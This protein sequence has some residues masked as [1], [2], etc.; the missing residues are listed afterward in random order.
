MRFAD[1]LLTI[2]ATATLTSAA[3][4]VVGTIYLGNSNI[5]PAAPQAA[6]TDVSAGARPPSAALAQ[7]GRREQISAPAVGEF[8]QLVMPV[9]SVRRDQLVDTFDDPRSGGERLHQA[10]DIMAPRGAPVVAA[11]P[12][13]I[14]R[15]FQ[16]EAGGNTVYVR[17][18]DRRTIYYYAHLD[19]YAAG[20]A[21]G[22]RVASG[23]PL[24][25]VGSTGNASPDA[26][27]LHFA[28]LRTTPDAGWSDPATA[29]DPFPL[30]RR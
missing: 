18:G 17:S 11:A 15:L 8:A 1:R 24:G 4:I 2:V 3:W 22:A 25:T 12:G 7:G 9:P 29:L 23:T 26:P 30:L 20:L 6:S 21:E 10:L 14:E 19:G 27:H 5:G 16:S 13:T 28:I